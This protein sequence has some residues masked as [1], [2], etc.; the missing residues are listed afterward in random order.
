MAIWRNRK[1]G[2]FKL[3]YGS[4]AKVEGPAVSGEQLWELAKHHHP[5]SPLGT[6]LF[7]GVPSTA[8]FETLT[9]PRRAAISGEPAKSMISW[10]DE[11]GVM[12]YT[13][14]GVEPDLDPYWVRYTDHDAQ[15]IEKRFR[16]PP[17]A[18][19]KTDYDAWI[20]SL[21]EADKLATTGA[22]TVR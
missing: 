20:K 4:A 22:T 14:F 3:G 5:G 17:W 8:D 6:K 16:R 13:T 2:K 21:A 1:T 9:A 18:D 7:E 10:L 15:V 12:H 11:D 19:G